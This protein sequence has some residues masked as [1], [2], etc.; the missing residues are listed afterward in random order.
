MSGVNWAGGPAQSLSSCRYLRRRLPHD[1]RQL[2][3]EPIRHLLL[4]AQ[5][6]ATHLRHVLLI[7]GPSGLRE[8]TVAR[9]LEMFGRI[10]GQSILDRLVSEHTR[11]DAVDGAE[12]RAH[13][14]L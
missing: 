8:R 5:N 10:I 9:Y 6:L 2:A 13:R 12:Q 1:L 3:V 7:G 14:R 4:I 11:R